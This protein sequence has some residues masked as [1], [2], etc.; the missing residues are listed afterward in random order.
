[1]SID[2]NFEQAKND[3]REIGFDLYYNQNFDYYFIT[4]S[5][6]KNII[7]RFDKFI[8]IEDFLDTNFK[9]LYFQ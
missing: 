7:K 2:N 6:L 1:M 4:K 9:Q 5:G 8:E 3:F